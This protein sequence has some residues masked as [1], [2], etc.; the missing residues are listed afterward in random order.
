MRENCTSGLMREGR[1]KPALY[2]TLVELFFD[3]LA[4]REGIRVAEQE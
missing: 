4:Q 1:V 2:S 3:C